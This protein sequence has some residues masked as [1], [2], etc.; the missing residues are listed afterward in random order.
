MSQ[1]S[2]T[3]SKLPSNQF[4]HFYRGGNRI[5]ALRH[6]PGGPMRPEE[7][8][9]SI[10]T[11]FGEA[12]QGL[13]HLSDG[14]L[15]RDAIK[16]DSQGW[17]GEDHVKN[18]GLST[19]ILIK[20]LDPDQRL[21]V[22]YHPNKA[23]AKTHLGLDH[24]K[25][26]AWII[27]EAP[28]GSG[29][30]LGFS[31]TQNKEDLL[32]LVRAQDSAALLASLRRSEVKVGDAVL[33]PAGVAHAIDAGIFVLELQEPTDLSAL[34]E[35]EGFAVDGIKDGHLGLGFETVTDALMLDPLSDSEFD[36][37]I[38]HNVFSGGSLR[39]V[40]PLKSD[41]YF[42]AHLAPG[43]GDFPAG[44]AVAL[45]LDG[46][47]AIS[48]ANAPEMAITKGDAVVIPHSAGAFTFSGANAIICRPP[49]AELARVA[50]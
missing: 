17:L 2:T 28:A 13:S 36:S 14:T 18:F 7:W 16:N 19:E 9:G 29:V 48:F 32:K 44:F 43:S 47:G 20:L 22:H 11:R 38:T 40:L 5:G 4:D 35:W 34:L 33:V 21:P 37:L 41:G 26:E 10:T 46:S 8:I 6:G 27:L 30:G 3:P 15:L 39:S 24:G 1:S 45:V 49:L 42:R 31:Q 12:E 25:T 23:F 50:P